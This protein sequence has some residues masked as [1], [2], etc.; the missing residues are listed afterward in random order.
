[1]IL[2]P[3]NWFWGSQTW[4]Q[5]HTNMTSFSS[6][7]HYLCMFKKTICGPYYSLGYD[8]T[9]ENCVNLAKL[10]FKFSNFVET[11]E[12][13]GAPAKR[14]APDYFLW[15]IFH[16]LYDLDAQ[17]DEKETWIKE[18]LFDM[19]GIREGQLSC[20]LHSCL[21]IFQLHPSLLY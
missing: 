5:M 4:N 8:D 21:C 10:I 3:E 16:C 7:L 17:I 18:M 6:G 19:G 9:L 14:P 11:Q 15:S 20:V 2:V 12:S 1:M 13:R